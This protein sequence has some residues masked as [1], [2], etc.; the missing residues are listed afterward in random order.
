ML[1][2]HRPNAKEVL[3]HCFFWNKGIFCEFIEAVYILTEGN[4]YYRCKL[5]ED[6]TVIGGDWT[7]Y[8]LPRAGT[9]IQLHCIETMNRTISYII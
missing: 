2:L 1:Y 5:D 8:K 3:G 6:T 9:G 4:E 7:K